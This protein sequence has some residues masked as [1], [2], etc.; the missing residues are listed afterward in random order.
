MRIA[1]PMDSKM[2]RHGTRTGTPP[3]RR[4]SGSSTR[5]LRSRAGARVERTVRAAG[6]PGP[7]SV[8]SVNAQPES[9]EADG[10]PWDGATRPGPPPPPPLPTANLPDW[11]RDHVRSVAAFT[12]RP[13]G[14]AVMFSL[15]GLSTALANKGE[16]EVR[17][18]WTEPL[19]VW[20]MT[21]L[22]PANRKS[23]VLRHMLEPVWEY[24]RERVEAAAGPREHALE[25]REALEHVLRS[26]Q[27]ERARAIA[28]GEETDEIREQIGRLREALADLPVPAPERLIV[29]DVTPEALLQ[30]MAQ[31]YG[32]GA[33]LSAE[34]EIFR[35]MQGRYGNDSPML[36]AFKKAWTGEE[37]IRDDR[38]TRKGTQIHRPALT[39]GLGLQP[40]L[41][42]SL[43]QKKSFRGEGIFGRFLAIQP[44][45]S[46]GERETGDDVPSLDGTARD[47][48]ERNLRTLLES[49]P[50][51]E[52]GREWIPHTLSLT[53][54]AG[55]HLAEFEAE[56]E[57]R[58]RTDLDSLKDWAGKLVGNTA[59]IAGLLHVATQAEEGDLWSKPISVGPTRTVIDLATSLIPHAKTV[60]AE[61]A[62]D[63]EIQLQRYVL[64]RI[65][66]AEDPEALTVRDVHRLCS[67]KKEIETVKDVKQ[68]L[69]RLRDHNLVRIERRRSNNGR[70]PSP[71]VRLHPEL[72]EDIDR[73]DRTRAGEPARPGGDEG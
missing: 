34:G 72:H 12:Q 58:L 4:A 39:M 67:G 41:L 18:G 48:Y 28:S 10:E 70:R 61:M 19:N 66:Q 30:L 2:L 7:A 47:R 6:R 62:M 42:R 71:W 22:E 29:D 68:V 14:M 46:A 17:S 5:R 37:H 40:E 15:A 55:E 33:L 59:R 50:A 26:K 25:E 35:Y 24:E 49:T 38:V 21:I 1:E 52:D 20:T 9:E 43:S 51:R 3:R 45:S 8:S 16:V 36:N 13:P 54:D 53:D 44:P 27:K 32:R 31:N 69:R 65:K 11:I 56:I 64:R 23:A 63:P 60:F 73:T 57:R